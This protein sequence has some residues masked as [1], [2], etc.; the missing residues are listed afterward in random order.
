MRLAS[1]TPQTLSRLTMR[2]QVSPETTVYVFGFAETLGEGEGA[3]DPVGDGDGDLETVGE[4]VGDGDFVTVGD[5]DG[6]AL[7]E[8]DGL[9]LGVFDPGTKTPGSKISVLIVLPAAVP[10]LI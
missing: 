1:V 10:V 5:G 6:E 3:L 8:G 9:G 2:D 7:T 4:G